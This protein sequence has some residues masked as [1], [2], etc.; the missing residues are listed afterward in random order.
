MTVKIGIVGAGFAG[1]VL[2]RELALESDYDI[3]IVDERNHIAGNCH[4]SRDPASDIMIHHYGPHIF[5]TDRKDIWDYIR[6]FGEFGPYVNRVRAVTDK[7]V[8]SLPI[9]L[10]TINQYFH[11]RFSPAEAEVFIRSLGDESITDPQSFEEQAIKMLGV[12]LYHSFFY[13]Y[14]KKQWGV[15]PTELSASILK[16]LPVRF[17][18]DDNY[19][20]SPYQG[21][22]L[23]GYTALAEQMING[24]GVRIRLGERYTPALQA[25]FDHVF[26]SGPMDG[27]YGYDLGRLQYRSLTFER[28]EADGDHQGNAVINYC[29]QEVP[30]TRI[31]EHKHF[32]PW[33]KHDKTVY[34]REYSS[35]TGPN[36][37]PYYPMRLA[38][39]KELLT[40]Y[41][42]RAEKDAGV[43]FIGRLGTYRYLDMHVVIRES[44]ELAA[45]CLKAPLE[46]W[47]TFSGSPL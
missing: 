25:E 8:F 3:T 9:N 32:T 13:G 27:Y 29:E 31:A 12:E 41:T 24:T 28:F 37:V 38:A 45:H 19:Y 2:A 10:L 43:T 20:N 1:L 18:Y 17:T 16:R 33:E 44:I 34:F 39:D 7:G 26:F 40:R 4:T 30:Y 35:V 36:D 47:P 6:Q 11:Q 46:Y 22:P 15:E 21:I 14:T 5:H 42:A 23:D